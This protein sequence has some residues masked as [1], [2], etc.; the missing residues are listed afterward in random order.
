[1]EGGLVIVYNPYDSLELQSSIL[2]Y[3]N[4]IKA[5]TMIYSFSYDVSVTFDIL[6]DMRNERK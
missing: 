4:S 6:V 3:P 5:S 2:I 1:V